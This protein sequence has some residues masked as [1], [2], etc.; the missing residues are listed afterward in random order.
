MRVHSHDVSYTQSE[1]TEPGPKRDDALTPAEKIAPIHEALLAV[2]GQPTWR[3][4]HP[5]MDELVLTIL[6]Q[7]TSD[8]NSGRAFEHLRA[9]FPTWE[10]VRDAPVAAIATAIQSGGLAQAKAP[11]IKA[12]LQ[13]IWDERGSFDLDFL[14]TV[15]LAEAEA[16]LA[17]LPGVGPKT[18][19]CVL[20]FACG[21]PAMPVDTHIHRVSRR[22]GLVPDR[23]SAEQAHELLEG[24]VPPEWYYAFHLN[25]IKHGREVCK[26]P[27][28]RCE[29]CVL[30]PWCD[31]YKGGRP[32]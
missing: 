32:G 11:R 15:P 19:A 6:S 5:P 16:W 14:K 13:R 12:I 30:R 21:R 31:Y 18:A 20:L 29:L 3:P 4:H 7:H 1:Q 22:L 24:L 17:A 27:R 25:V 26:A 23:A 10:E 8:I 2:Y 28:P 9:A